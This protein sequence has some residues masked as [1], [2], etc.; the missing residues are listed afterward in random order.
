M[1]PVSSAACICKGQIRDWSQQG[2]NSPLCSLPIHHRLICNIINE[3]MCL[4][5]FINI[6]WHEIMQVFLEVELGFLGNYP[7]QFVN[8]AEVTGTTSSTFC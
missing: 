3:L 2:Q 5:D 1:S 4:A 8:S 6:H 7:R